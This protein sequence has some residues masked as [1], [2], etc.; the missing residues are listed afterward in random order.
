MLEAYRTA[1]GRASVNVLIATLKKL[2]Y[3]YPY[4]QVVGFYMQR[5]DFPVTSLE[6]LQRL[7][8]EFDFYLTYGMREKEFISDW[9][10]F[11]PKGF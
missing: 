5:A 1:R 6:A 11:V 7:G 8:L 9:R 4:H 3:V 10:L 2:E